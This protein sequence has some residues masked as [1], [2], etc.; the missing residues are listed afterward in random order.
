MTPLETKLNYTFKDPKLL[1]TALTHSSFANENAVESY[2]RLEFLGDSILGMVVAEFLFHHKPKLSE[3]VLTR[4]RSNLV[5][6]EALVLVADHLELGAVIRLGKGEIA[7]GARPS[8]RADVVEAILAGIFLD[9]GMEPAKTM[10]HHFVLKDFT[11]QISR[12]VDYKTAL[13]EWVQRTSGTVI[14]YQ[15]LEEKGPDHMKEF[16]IQVEVNGQP[17]GEGTGRSKKE[18][19]QNAAKSA[20]EKLKQ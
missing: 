2:E 15:L 20:L 13:Q 3:G 11:P 8:I 18:A 6:E 14:A 10:V 16:T 17:Q 4:T 12:T 7:Q 5:R 19:E 1:Q 9:G